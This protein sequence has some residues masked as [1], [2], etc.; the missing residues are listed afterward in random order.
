MLRGGLADDGGW[1]VDQVRPAVIVGTVDLVG[2]RLRTGDGGAAPRRRGAPRRPE[3]AEAWLAWRRDV[4]DLVRTDPAAAAA[5]L[6]FYSLRAAELARVPM[7]AAKE[8][9]REA[10]G[11]E[12]GRGLLVVVR[13]DGEVR[14]A[15]VHDGAQLPPLA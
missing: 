11:R 12:E 2:S 7:P 4:A 5:A 10:I 3:V 9:V 14:A 13:G 6:S 1:W 15:V 8:I